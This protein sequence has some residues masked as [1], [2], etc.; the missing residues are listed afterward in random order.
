M[1]RRSPSI[2]T[3]VLVLIG[4]LIA[5]TLP[6]MAAS[7][8]DPLGLGIRNTVTRKTKLIRTQPGT[9]FHVVARAGTPLRLVSKD[10]SA[11]LRVNSSVRVP[12]LNADMVDGRHASSFASS[13][14]TC[15]AG[16]VFRGLDSAGNL[17]CSRA[18]DRWTIDVD[19]ADP[20][21]AL[22]PSGNPII[23]YFDTKASDLKVAECH[24][25]ICSA[26]TIAN[27]DVTDIVGRFPSL[28]LRGG[29][30]PIVAYFDDT[31]S[32]LKVAACN[33]PSCIS[34][35]LT[36]VDN[37]ASVG[38]SPSIVLG[39]DGFP[40]IA[41]YDATTDDL[42]VADCS[43]TTCSAKTL[44]T[45]DTTGDVGEFTSIVL[46]GDGNPIIAYADVTGG[47]L[48]VA[49]CSNT[50]CS[51]RNI[52]IADGTDGVGEHISMV[53]GADG[54]PLISYRGSFSGGT[55]LVADCHDSTCSG[56]TVTPLDWG[57]GRNVFET[58]ITL[59]QDGF[60]VVAYSDFTSKDLMVAQG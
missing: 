9:A 30:L 37:T 33:V 53:I 38:W 8:G 45:V 52:T 49:D 42:K 17:V 56:A 40:I 21:I 46:G 43:N 5:L 28:T 18:L 35:T 23:A 19:G 32:S 22:H 54:F 4:A 50:D 25:P 2:K 59:G 7:V 44:T 27:V 16:R 55:L 6:A 36:T 39:G 1:S 24:D 3:V 31:N 41:Y 14:Q 20:S 10:G 15:A 57:V 47:S 29:G 60:P 12:R 26:R 13:G 58:S 34:K 11:P 48:K 51:S